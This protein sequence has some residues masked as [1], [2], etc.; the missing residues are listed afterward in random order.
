MM[1]RYRTG[2]VR[3][4]EAVISL[5]VTCKALIDMP[6]LNRTCV[7]CQQDELMLETVRFKVYSEYLVHLSLTV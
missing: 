7:T 3:V 6:R 4:P 5:I 1:M 2:E